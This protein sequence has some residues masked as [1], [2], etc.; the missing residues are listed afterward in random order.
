MKAI[1]QCP[2]MVL[3]FSGNANASA[4]VH[5]EVDRA[6]SKGVAVVPLRV[7]NVVPDEGLA[8]YLNTVHWLDAPLLRWKRVCK[9]SSP[10][11]R[12]SRR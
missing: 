3:I 10:W 12:L 1:D 2:V 5:R 8:Y 7:E 11:F 9:N 6:F 4:Q